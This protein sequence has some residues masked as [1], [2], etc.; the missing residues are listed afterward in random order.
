MGKCLVTKLNGTVN[1]NSLLRI[2]EL[3]LE[4]TANSANTEILE[5]SGAECEYSCDQA[6]ILDTSR[7]EAHVRQSVKS[8][9]PIKSVDA[10][11]YRFHLFNKYGIDG[12]LSKADGEK[13]DGYTFLNSLTELYLR[14]VDD[15]DISA[16]ENITAL[17]RLQISGNVSGDLACLKALTSLTSLSLSSNVYGDISQLKNLT[18]LTTLNINGNNV[19]GDISQL[20]ALASLTSL[21]LNGTLNMDLTSSAMS[22]IPARFIVIDWKTMAGKNFGDIA[23][24][25]PNLCCI[26]CGSGVSYTWSSRPSS[27]K[28]IALPANAAIDNLDKMLQ[29]QAQCQVGFT[30]SDTNDYKTIKAVG[31]R[32]SASDSAVSTLKSKG[33]TVIVNNVTL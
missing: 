31:T 15:F 9:K 21:S 4:L 1:D 11:T 30:S 23:V 6:H 25:H 24:M 28:I 3:V 19:Y 20:K 16:L 2:G 8:W 14:K 5:L 17:K 10:G 32:T 33:Y 29:D 26:D 22:E 27:S 13:C 12:I 18:N 7:V